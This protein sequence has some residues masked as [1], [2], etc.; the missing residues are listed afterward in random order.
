MCTHPFFHLWD[1]T[2]HERVDDAG[3]KI[4]CKELMNV[5]IPLQVFFYP[6]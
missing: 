5:P 4:V 1:V 6:L 2:G 3:D